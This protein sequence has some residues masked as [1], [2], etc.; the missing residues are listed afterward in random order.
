MTGRVQP[1]RVG[2]VEVLIE[3]SPVAEVAPAES[4]RAGDVAAKVVDA[5]SE[6]E[7]AIVALSH[8]VAAVAE[9]AVAT[10]VRP[11]AMEVEFGLKV[12]AEGRVVIAAA[13]AEA[14][15]TVKLIYDAAG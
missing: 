15:L 14:S 7:A 5:F 2:G 13:S 6:V 8:R 4:S 9:Q 11:S 3:A 12:T 1:M 10:A